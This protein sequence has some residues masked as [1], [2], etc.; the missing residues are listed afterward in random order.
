MAAL[1]QPLRRRVRAVIDRHF[2]RRQYDAGRTVAAFSDHLRSEVDLNRLAGDL[3]DV[4][5][6]T[7]QPAHVS[8]WLRPS[9]SAS[10]PK[11]DA[12]R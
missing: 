4:V 5:N 9:K 3:V 11:P 7:V 2:Y 12:E 6:S 10:K 1:F 8:L